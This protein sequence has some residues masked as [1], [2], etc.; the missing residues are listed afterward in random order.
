MRKR[1]LYRSESHPNSSSY[2]KSAKGLSIL[3]VN[4][5][6]ECEEHVAGDGED[7]GFKY[8]VAQVP[9]SQREVVCRRLERYPRE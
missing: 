5:Y 1:S 9:K 6:V 8:G 7:V 2:F 4:P 3:L